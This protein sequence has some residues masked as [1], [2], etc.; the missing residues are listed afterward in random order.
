[1]RV[2]VVHNQTTGLPS[3]E[4]G[5]VRDEV[6]GLRAL[7][8]EIQLYEEKG[9]HVDKMSLPQKAWTAANLAWSFPSMRQMGGVIDEFKPDVAHFHSVLPQ[10]TPSV[11]SACHRRGVPVV[12][13]LHNF[14]WL[15]VE[16]GLYRRD[17]FCDDCITGSS[18]S[19]A[20]HRCARGSA[21][22]STLLTAMNA[23]YLRTGLLFRLVDAF[24]S[25]SN[26]VRDTYVSGGFPADKIHVKYNGVS[27][28]GETPAAG[29]RAGIIY[30]GRLSGAKG[31]RHLKHV[32]KAL[33][34]VPFKVVGEGPDVPGLRT[35]AQDNGLGEVEFLGR[36]EPERVYGL[37]AAAECAL[38]PSVCGETFGRVALEA[39]S[40]G[41]PVVGSRIGG[42]AEL[43][44]GN[45]GAIAVDPESSEQ[46]AEAV[47]RIIGSTEV[48]ALM[49]Q[50]GREFV[51]QSRFSDSAAN[52]LI[53]IYEKVIDEWGARRK[54]SPGS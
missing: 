23:M 22:L 14:R 33:P 13:T 4:A 41:T 12:Q 44:G 31:T 42:L 38:V 16:G 19:G 34:Q 48:V 52:G 26:F 47:E 36:V 30:V 10:L 17:S 39:M 3:G 11:F 32:M 1:M 6:A 25:V 43:L 51:S 53:P 45:E 18:L 28:V 54:G 37:L 35:F 40:V 29:E 8:H 2:L 7:G 15:C 46:F 50:K 20:Y 27:V 21:P 5:V 49:G 24:V 9:E